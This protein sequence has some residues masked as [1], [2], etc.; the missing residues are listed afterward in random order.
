MVRRKLVTLGYIL[1]FWGFLPGI[2]AALADRG[3]RIF[4]PALR[5][6]NLVP[7]ALL[8]AGLSGVMLALSIIQY[9]RASGSLPISA[10]PPRQ[11][12]RSGVFGIWRHP[13]Y[14]FS[15]FYFTG[16][17]MIFRPAGAIMAVFPSLALG[18]FIYARVEERGLR[19]RFGSVYDGHR[20]QTSRRY[21]QPLPQPE[22]LP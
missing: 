3:E 10:F 9:T 15:V 17:A 12:L 20:R 11:L 21:Y 5:L 6:P 19:R 22:R 13:I 16:L 8:L 14:L 4:G 2:L 18:T 7:A 1:V